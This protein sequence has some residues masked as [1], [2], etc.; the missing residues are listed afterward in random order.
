ML[1]RA[2]ALAAAVCTTVAL[3]PPNIEAAP[4]EELVERA[5][6]MIGLEFGAED[7]P[8]AE[9]LRAVHEEVSSHAQLAIDEHAQ[10]AQ[11]PIDELNGDREA[12]A[13]YQS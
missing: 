13:P 9:R 7:V 6:A 5:A 12:L 1:A 4:L 11:I 8:L 10:L 2:A 3:S